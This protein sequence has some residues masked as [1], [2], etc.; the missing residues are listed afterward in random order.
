[1][2][3]EPFAFTMSIRDMIYLFKRKRLYLLLAVAMSISLL[4]IHLALQPRTVSFLVLDD[5]IC[6]GCIQIFM[7]ICDITLLFYSLAHPG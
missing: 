5:M 4:R 1:M 7:I 6:R 2:I 3:E